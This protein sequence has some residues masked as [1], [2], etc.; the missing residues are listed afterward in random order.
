MYL[1]NLHPPIPVSCVFCNERGVL[2]VVVAWQLQ[3]Q[4]SALPMLQTE[5]CVAA[6]RFLYTWN[7]SYLENTFVVPFSSG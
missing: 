6:T 5:E 2:D 1:A 4:L 3:R 7:I